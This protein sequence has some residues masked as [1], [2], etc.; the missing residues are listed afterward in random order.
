MIPRLNSSKK[1]TSL[2]PELI[3]QIL[4]VFEEA[5]EKQKMSGEFIAEGRIY[6][7]ELM[8]RMGYI[9]SG[10]LKQVNFEVSLDF[11]SAKQNALEQIHLAID[12]AASMVE[13]YFAEPESFDDMPTSW[14]PLELDGRKLFVQVSTENTKLEEQAN[15]LLGE[16][17]EDTLVIGDDNEEI[18]ATVKT[19]LG[20]DPNESSEEDE[21]DV[22]DGRDRKDH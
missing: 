17:G 7:N 21:D 22:K 18:E 11:N 1:W 9:E 4:T 14:K 16:T 12:C 6:Q 15:A 13:S 2:P 5:F 20:L 10:R 19:M 3:A 8:F